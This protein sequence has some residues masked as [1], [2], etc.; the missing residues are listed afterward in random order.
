MGPDQPPLPRPPDDP[1]NLNRLRE[2]ARRRMEAES[3][4]DVPRP[5]YGGPP[6][7][8]RRWTL[9]GIL[10][11]IAGAIAAISAAIWGYQKVAVPVYGGPPVPTPVPEPAPVSPS[12][13]HA[14]PV[15]G[16]P[17]PQPAPEPPVSKAPPPAPVYGAPTPPSK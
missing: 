5:V 2:E 1:E 12:P 14:A 9:R 6:I 3:L 17:P 7:V 15:Y 10:L 16:G 8:T 11:L 4:R 13:T